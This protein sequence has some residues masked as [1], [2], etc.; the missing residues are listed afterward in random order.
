M[1]TAD[2]QSPARIPLYAPE[3]AADPHAA[4]E[5]MRTT[6]GTLVPV[7]LSPGIPATLVIGYDAARRILN[8]PLRFPADPRVWQREVP[9]TCPVLPMMEWRPNALRSGGT[10]HARY[11]GANTASLDAV[12]QH[13]L[14][15]LV[16]KIAA[17][18]IAGFGDTGRAD[19]LMQ[20]AWPIS[21]R[22]LSALL[23]CPDDIGARIADGMAKIFEAKDADHGNALL[24]QAIGELV[25]LRREHPGDDVTSRLILHEAALDDEEMAHQLVTLYGAGIEPLTNLI[26]NTQLKILTDD[27]FSAEL[28]AGQSTLRDALDTVLYSDPPMANYCISYPPYPTDMDGYLLPA[29]QPVVIS[30]S[31]CNNDPELTLGMPASSVSGNRAH[32]AW[33][34]GPHTCPARSH[35]YLIA[36]TAL[37][38]LLD[39]IPEM[40]LA[41]P[42]SEL[43]WRPGPFHRALEALPVLFPVHR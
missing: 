2:P 31:A 22:V 33:S 15:A 38:H 29:H 35:A 36:E 7:E 25:V 24:A 1:T 43:R 5:R 28:H 26:A 27:D 9:R 32:L 8:D 6:H 19:L 40:D 20:Y 11:R 10:E 34:I 13:Q 17:Q 12:D 23:G 37:S 42:P 39:A 41:V 4:Y 21:F 16:E 18:A 3:F 30:L 14:R